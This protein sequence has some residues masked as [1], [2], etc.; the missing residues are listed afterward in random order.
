MLK[1]VP[2]PPLSTEIS[3]SLEDLLVQIS[4][5][6][7]CALSII[8]LNT[9]AHFTNIGRGLSLTSTHKIEAARQLAELALSKLQVRH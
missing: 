3:H 7:F 8:H 9:P 4:E 2:D 1:I 5:R 6:L